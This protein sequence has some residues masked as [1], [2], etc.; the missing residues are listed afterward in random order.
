L[1]RAKSTDTLY[2][3]DEQGMAAA[4]AVH[5]L[6]EAE[7]L[8]LGSPFNTISPL[9]AQEMPVVMFA[10]PKLDTL[11][12]D[13]YIVTITHGGLVK[14]SSIN[15]LHG[16][17]AQTFRLVNVNNGDRLGWAVLTDGFKEL[18]LVTASGMAIRFK[19]TNVRP[20]GLLA[21]GVN[22]IKL[23]VGDEVVGC[24]VLPTIGE[25]MLVASDGKAKRVEVDDFPTQGRYGKGVIAWEMSEGVKL[26][27]ISSGK[28]N[29]I[30]TLHLLKAASKMSRLDAAPIRKRSAVRGAP[31]VTL[32]AGDAVVNLT[33]GWEAE[34]YI[35]VKR[36]KNS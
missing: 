1:T 21:A 12:K 13:A 10:L 29:S 15:N 5:T 20:M 34:S 6:P 18:L 26:V 23:S 2:L 36:N 4:V 22:G 17:S 35:V 7:K 19:E 8:G 3:T 16:P 27:G 28:K 9:R 24:E 14:K 25:I 33:Q 11:P 30:I 32:K 31:L